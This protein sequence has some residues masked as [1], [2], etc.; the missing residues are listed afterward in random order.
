MNFAPK[1]AASSSGSTSVFTAVGEKFTTF[2]KDISDVTSG[3]NGIAAGIEAFLDTSSVKSVENKIKSSATDAANKTDANAFVNIFGDVASILTGGT[4]V[5]KLAGDVIGLFTGGSNNKT[6]AATPSVTSVNL[7]LTGTLTLNDVAE[8]FILRVPG[9]VQSGNNNATYYQC[10]LGIFNL[11]VTPQADTLMYSRTL[12]D[13]PNT[14]ITYVAYRMRGTAIPVSYFSGTG[15][16]LLSVKA[17]LMGQILADPTSK[18]ASYNPL[19]ADRTITHPG[20]ETW[21]TVN[22]MR[23]DF[24]SGRLDMT[25]FDTSAAHLH[26]FQTPY[27]N[28]ECLQGQ[29]VNV[30]ASTNVFLRV[31]AILKRS[32]DPQ[33]KPILYVQDYKLDCFQGSL[34][35]ATRTRL[36]NPISIAMPP[37]AN[38]TVS[39]SWVSDR[40][41][42]NMTYTA[43]ATE[44]ADNSLTAN[45]AVTVSAS[46]QG[47]VFEAGNGV[48]LEPGFSALPGCNFQAVVDTY[49]APA[50]TC[51]TQQWMGFTT[52]SNCYNSSAAAMSHKADTAAAQSMSL[53]M[54]DSMVNVYPVPASQQV[55][56]TGLGG[57]GHHATI[58]FIDQLGRTVYTVEKQDDSPTMVLNVGGLSSGVYFVEIRGT[59]VTLTRKIVVAH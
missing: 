20:G 12:I 19:A 29:S 21:I 38:Y 52:S 57:L 25:Y 55:T 30:P 3:V 15:L 54:V 23:P 35:Q 37:Y 47:V 39:P 40:T 49:G 33:N 24:E 41:I 14:P 44:E 27:V 36:L 32:D 58:S 56:L 7:T 10:P 6:P 34:D 11:N 42:S 50:L 4:S 48:Y 18:K 1:N 13:G 46:A 26:L 16:T 51:N 43:A 2:S 53:A 9:T 17:A 22:Y 8:T 45:T 59:A 28:L 5:L 31:Q